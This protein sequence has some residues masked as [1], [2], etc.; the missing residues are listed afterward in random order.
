MFSHSQWL[1]I[2]LLFA[3]LSGNLLAVDG[4]PKA[5]TGPHGQSLDW[6]APGD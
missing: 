2:S 3:G 1:A 4:V 6:F 5:W